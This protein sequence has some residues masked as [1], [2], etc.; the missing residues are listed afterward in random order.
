MIITK[1]VVKRITSKVTEITKAGTSKEQLIK[2]IKT[3]VLQA[4]ITKG[5]PIDIAEDIAAR[6]IVLVAILD[7]MTIK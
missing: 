4:V 1:H 6:L 2:E 5:I 3:Y 7:P